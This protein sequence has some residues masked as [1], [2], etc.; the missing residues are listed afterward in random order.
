RRVGLR[1]DVHAGLGRAQRVVLGLGGLREDLERVGPAAALG[2]RRRGGR[3]EDVGA[4][5]GDAQAVL[6][7]RGQAGGLERVAAQGEEV[8]VG[9]HLVEAEDV[10][11]GV[12]DALEDIG[13]GPRL[14][15]GS[16]GRGGGGGVL[17]VDGPVEDVAGQGD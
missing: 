15:G 9:G 12:P 14:G 2:E 5:D 3:G 17:L 11:E 10:A 13:G 8:G 6:E 7:S 16:S 4:G 1:R